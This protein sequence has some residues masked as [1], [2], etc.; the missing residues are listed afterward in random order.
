[1]I[2][3]NE[4]VVLHYVKLR[5]PLSFQIWFPKDAPTYRWQMVNPRHQTPQGQSVAN[6]SVGYPSRE[7]KHEI[8]ES[9]GHMFNPIFKGNAQGRKHPGKWAFV[10]PELL[11]DRKRKYILQNKENGYKNPSN[12]HNHH[13]EVTLYELEKGTHNGTQHQNNAKHMMNTGAR[14]TWCYHNLALGDTIF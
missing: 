13:G 14:G 7:S 9:E 6:S 5:S 12:N 3:N 11:R 4:K 8:K 1:M 10:E 2:K